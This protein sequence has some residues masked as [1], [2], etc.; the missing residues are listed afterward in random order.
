MFR[1]LA[2]HTKLHGVMKPNKISRIKLSN[3]KLHPANHAPNF[4]MLLTLLALDVFIRVY[5][6]ISNAACWVVTPAYN[7]TVL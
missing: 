4:I 3:V 1:N 7:V 5:T 2:Q 6:P